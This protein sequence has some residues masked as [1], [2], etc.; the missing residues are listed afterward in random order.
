MTLGSDTH[1]G[2]RDGEVGLRNLGGSDILDRIALML[3]SGS[4][5]GILQLH[6]GIQRIILRSGLL[7]GN[8]II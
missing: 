8:T 5:E 4:I 2:I 6:I 7:L 3:G 1:P